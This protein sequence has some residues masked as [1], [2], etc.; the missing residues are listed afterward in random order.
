MSPII[1]FCCDI[2]HGCQLVL[3]FRKGE[4]SKGECS[5]EIILH[6]RPYEMR[7]TIHI[8]LRISIHIIDL[9]N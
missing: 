6:N 2:S 5:I 1:S 8:I 7:I 9:K 4:C 3:K